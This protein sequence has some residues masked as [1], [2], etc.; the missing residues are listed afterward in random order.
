VAQVLIVDDELDSRE[1]VSRFLVRVGH[2]VSCADDG[3]DALKR[4]L[5]ETP[6]VMLLDVRMPKLDGVGLLEILRSYLRWSALPVILLTGAA[7]PDEMRRARDMGV[8]QIL[9][10]AQFTLPERGAAIDDCMGMPPKN[11]A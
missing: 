5:V 1:A 11:L 9:H 6:D 7:T 4:L 8:C 2:R 3:Q 10:K